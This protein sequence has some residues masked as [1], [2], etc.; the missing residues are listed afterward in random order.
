[1][2]GSLFPVSQ[3]SQWIGSENTSQSAVTNLA[4]LGANEQWNFRRANVYHNAYGFPEFEHPGV[5]VSSCFTEDDLGFGATAWISVLAYC[6]YD[7]YFLGIETF[8]QVVYEYYN[9]RCGRPVYG[10]KVTRRLAEF[11]VPSSCNVIPGQDCL[12]TGYGKLRLDTPLEFTVNGNGTTSTF[13]TVP[14][15]QTYGNSSPEVESFINEKHAAL[16]S[17][18]T[19]TFRITSQQSCQA[20]DCACGQSLAGIQ[21]LFFGETF[22]VGN[23]PNDLRGR[24]GQRWEYFDST[25]SPSVTYQ[26]SNESS[27]ETYYLASAT[28]SCDPSDSPETV[29]DKWLVTVSATCF[30]WDDDGNGGRE[31]TETTT[32]TWVG[33]YI[34]NETCG[35]SLP[36][37]SPTQMVLVSTVTT[38]GLGSCDPGGAPT[39]FISSAPCE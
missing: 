6:K 16:E 23:E 39:V 26:S 36:S 32:K 33:E 20:A 14:V 37:G 19:G 10:R 18:L 1:M 3:R 21:I 27:S 7:R 30:T 4:Y 11:E 25:T 28:I 13:G 17:F 2:L 5:D 34:C 35:R 31:V 29:P 9:A 22:T 8:V 15:W 38:P 24:D 12:Y